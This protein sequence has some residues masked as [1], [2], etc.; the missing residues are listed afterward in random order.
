MHVNIS[1]IPGATPSFTI[2]KSGA[3]LG[4]M[5]GEDPGQLTVPLPHIDH[6]PQSTNGW[7][8]RHA[9][10]DLVEGS[11]MITLLSGQPTQLNGRPL[12]KDQP[13]ELPR[14]AQLCCGQLTLTIACVGED[15][16]YATVGPGRAVPTA[17]PHATIGPGQSLRPL[18]PILMP[19]MG[20]LPQRPSGAMPHPPGGGGPGLQALSMDGM[21]EQ[22]RTL[23]EQTR[24]ELGRASSSAQ[25]AQQRRV[26]S[27][28]ARDEA[29]QA[30]IDIQT[31]LSREQL[32]AAASRANEAAAK[33]RANAD[34]AATARESARRASQQ[35]DEVSRRLRTL[36]DD[37]ART[38][39]GLPPRTP[40]RAQ[41]DQHSRDAETAA[42]QGERNAEQAREKLSDAERATELIAAAAKTAAGHSEEAQ[43][44]AARRSGEFAR[45]DRARLYL[46]RYGFVGVILLVAV[47]VGLLVG[48][49]LEASSEPA[50]P[51]TATSGR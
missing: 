45:R 10:F 41:F 23:L 39:S 36:A 6:G 32:L 31:S 26:A 34:R 37:I 47:A 27:E 42:S 15:N 4:R 50:V 13:T 18:G 33:T 30:I 51:P 46:Q 17:D 38:A 2:T 5:Q 22:V 44:L 48:Y 19:Q 21:F 9:Q 11:W 20:G 8:R 1:G 16:R 40:E 3:V 28:T 49:V 7:S 12:I 14:V 25:D 35:A 43:S 24:N 29:K